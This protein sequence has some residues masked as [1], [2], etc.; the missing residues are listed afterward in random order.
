MFKN[1]LNDSLDFSFKNKFKVAL[2]GDSHAGKSTTLN[3]LIHSEFSNDYSPTI[4]VDYYT[5]IVRID[6][7]HYK[8]SFW[9]LS[10]D[11]RFLPI[12]SS[13]YRDNDLIMIFI[14]CEKKIIPQANFWLNQINNNLNELPPLLFVLNKSH[15][16]NDDLNRAKMLLNNFLS[17]KIY[18]YKVIH[19]NYKIKKKS[20]DFI[21]NKIVNILMENNMVT[22][23]LA[24]EPLLKK[25]KTK[26]KYK[27]FTEFFSKI[28][29]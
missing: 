8:I 26:S 4:G 16:L 19:Y 7:Q 3:R 18:N 21:Q 27:C 9:D 2:I 11:D 23:D 28:F 13:Y 15:L 6:N 29:S 1:N 25:S 24:D 12:M 10:G 5:K 20:R 14:D 22:I 17:D